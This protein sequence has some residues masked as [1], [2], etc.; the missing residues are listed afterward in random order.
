MKTVIHQARG[1]QQ[2]GELSLIIHI[3]GNDIKPLPS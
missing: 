2:T 1:Q 3:V